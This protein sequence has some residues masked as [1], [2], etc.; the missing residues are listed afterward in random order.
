MLLLS[1]KPH[2]MQLWYMY[3]YY[4]NTG[5]FMPYRCVQDDTQRCSTARFRAVCQ[6][7]AVGLDVVGKRGT[8]LYEYMYMYLSGLVLIQS[9]AQVLGRHHCLKTAQ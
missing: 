8:Y 7:P 4:T 5:L 1:Q 2:K 6:K 9:P 3:M